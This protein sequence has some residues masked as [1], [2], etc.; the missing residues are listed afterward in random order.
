M[1]RGK[2]KAAVRRRQHR[3]EKPD[4]MFAC[5]GSE[6]SSHLGLDEKIA[7]RVT[8]F[9]SKEPSPDVSNYSL[10]QGP[11]Y[12]KAQ[13]SVWGLTFHVWRLEPTTMPGSQSFSA[14]LS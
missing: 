8:K 2:G 10:T 9:I 13:G 14:A 12:S 5:C 7:G 3:R 4:E 6:P 1:A 11:G